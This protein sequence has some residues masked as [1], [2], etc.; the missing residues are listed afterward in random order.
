MALVV[1]FILGAIWAVVTVEV[2]WM[3][4]KKLARHIRR[5]TNV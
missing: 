3:E 4:V 2:G 5:L 1:C